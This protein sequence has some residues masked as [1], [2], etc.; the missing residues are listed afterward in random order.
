MADRDERIE[1]LYH[2]GTRD[3]AESVVDLQDRLARIR[4][5]ARL[6]RKFL[7]NDLELYAVIE[8]D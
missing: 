2:E 8:C 7:I 4:D 1:T 3:L 5:A 6:H